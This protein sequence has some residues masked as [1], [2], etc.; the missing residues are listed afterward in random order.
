MT[1]Q[2]TTHDHAP[3]N[4]PPSDAP[5]AD[6]PAM[7]RP[8]AR[9]LET[10][11]DAWNAFVEAS[12][13]A[14]WLQAT[15]WA[16]VKQP[17]GWS[18]VRAAVDFDGRGGSSAVGGQVLVRRVR[19]LPWGLG[20]IPR[21]PVGMATDP[22]Q[23]AAALAAFTARLRVVAREHRLAEIRMEPETLAGQGVEEA[24]QGA[25]WKSVRRIQWHRT[26]LID[27]RK[28]EQEL[29]AEMHRK[30]RQ[31][32][33]KSR[34]LGIRVVTAGGERLEEY[35]R[36][37][38]DSARRAGMFARSFD[39]FRVLWDELA[40]RRMVHL[41]FAE[42]EQSGEP[43]ATLLLTSAGGRAFDMYGGTLVEGEKRRANYLLKWEALMRCK[44]EGFHEYDL[45]GL[46]HSGIAQFKAG[47]GGEEVTFVGAWSLATDRLGNAIL[48]AGLRA[49]G[50]YLALRYRG[51]GVYEGAPTEE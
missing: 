42:I 51:K 37:Y 43:V 33:T 18:A 46:P 10:D 12:T 9:T 6:E 45:W 17:N 11:D 28:P 44:A 22:Q 19:G 30:A 14:T 21:G 7:Q 26:R 49:R 23:A 24:L 25:G 36:I 2:P 40:P 41:S 48:A 50:A 29:W 15:P 38:T 20:Y 32:V 8:S 5:L 16:A 34:R 4:A 27:L 3:D 31:S 13:Q 47:F 35:H 39:T 1:A